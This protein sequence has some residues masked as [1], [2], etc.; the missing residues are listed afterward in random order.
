MTISEINHTEV[1]ISRPTSKLKNSPE[2]IKLLTI[3]LAKMDELESALLE[4]ANQK[5][6]DNVTGIWLD[7]IGKI[8]GEDRA[9]RDDYTY[10]KYLKLR[11]SI[12]QSDG[13]PDTITE[14]MQ[15]QVSADRARIFEGRYAWGQVILTEPSSISSLDLDILDQIR[16]VGTHLH[17]LYDI[18]GRAFTPAWEVTVTALELFE[19][20]DSTTTEALEL[21]LNEIGT[22]G[23]LYV[24]ADGGSIQYLPGVSENTTFEWEGGVELEVFDGTDT[25]DLEAQITD[26]VSKDVVVEGT[27]LAA[28]EL[29]ETT[30][31]WEVTTDHTGV[32]TLDATGSSLQIFDGSESFGLDLQVTETQAASLTIIV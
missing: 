4:L 3:F 29:E 8:V 10:R 17:L 6:I 13:T 24:N 26:T 16:P 2:F 12:N 18:D 19:V 5:D 14:I 20:Y 15:T 32:V 28:D 22:I 27:G 7:Y 25:F 9:G 21:I 11:V 31:F 23:N 30:L 1:G